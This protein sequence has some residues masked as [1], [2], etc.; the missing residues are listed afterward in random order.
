MRRR[1]LII[2]VD[3]QSAEGALVKGGSSQ[4]DVSE[5]TLMY[6]RLIQEFEILVCVDRVPTDSNI[7]DSCSRGSR[8]LAKSLGWH[9]VE[10][11]NAME[12]AVGWLGPG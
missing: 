5:L 7:S 8:E 6:W 3:S 11:P 1:K 10:I 4:E 12:W 2:F 9:E